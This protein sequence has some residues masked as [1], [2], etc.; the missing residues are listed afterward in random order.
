MKA[1]RPHFMT[2]KPS[3]PLRK[4]SAL[5]WRREPTRPQT[6]KFDRMLCLYLTVMTELIP[7]LRQQ[8]EDDACE[9]LAKFVR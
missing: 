1:D 4:A 3:A 7:W 8:S 2:L 6:W 5:Q 9:F